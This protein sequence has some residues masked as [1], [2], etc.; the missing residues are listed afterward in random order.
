MRHIADSRT[1]PLRDRGTAGF[2]FWIVLY[3][4]AMTLAMAAAYGS[5]LL[6]FG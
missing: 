1:A 2:A 3:A 5:E 4:V 6:T